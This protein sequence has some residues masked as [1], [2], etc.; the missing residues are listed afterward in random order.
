ML[1]QLNY[2][3][4]RE[5]Q[6]ICVAKTDKSHYKENRA[7]FIR[8]FGRQFPTA[9]GIGLITIT[10]ISKWEGYACLLLHRRWNQVWLM[11]RRRFKSPPES[12]QMS[13][14]SQTK[15]INL[16]ALLHQ[17]ISICVSRSHFSRHSMIVAVIY[18]IFMTNLL[19]FQIF[20]FFLSS[21]AA[22]VKTAAPDQPSTHRLSH[23]ER[24]RNLPYIL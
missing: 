3:Q 11:T 2:D 23:Q 5:K 1:S 19:S 12:D 9:A 10:V 6:L 21:F 4:K 7:N 8:S 17:T 20:S 24:W 13:H 15:A 16:D 22:C 14:S 18:Y